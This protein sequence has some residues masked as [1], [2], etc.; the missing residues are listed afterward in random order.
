MNIRLKAIRSRTSPAGQHFFFG[1]LFLLED[2]TLQ[3][4]RARPTL[5]EVLRDGGIPD[6]QRA[7]FE[8]VANCSR[9]G[10]RDRLAATRND[11]QEPPRNAL[12]GEG[13]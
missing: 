4:A 13:P 3:R 8:A 12:R 7:E 10:V 11:D 2:L 5:D 9:D 6:A 1:A